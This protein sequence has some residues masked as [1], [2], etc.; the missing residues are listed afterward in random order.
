M[1]RPTSPLPY[2]LPLLALIGL[3][4]VH[5]AEATDAP[6][7]RVEV[8]AKPG[9]PSDDEISQQVRAALAAEP[10]LNG[11]KINVATKGG[12]VNLTGLV[13]DQQLMVTAGHVAEKVPGVKYVLNEI[14]NEDYL[15]EKAA[16][17]Q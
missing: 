10:T 7:V 5:A 14:D 1:K 11:Q 2:L 3:S 15:R 16:K 12:E 8:P 4:H 6:K 9:T 13:S 17:A